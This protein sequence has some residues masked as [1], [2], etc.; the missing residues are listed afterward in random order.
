MNQLLIL[1]HIKRALMV[2]GALTLLL[3]AGC[4]LPADA[5]SSARSTPKVLKILQWEHFVPRYDEWFDSYA[6]Q[7]GETNGVTVVVDHVHV[8]ELG[9]T[10]TAE[11]AAGEGHDLI[12]HIIPPSRFEPDLSDLTDLNQEAQRRFG[13]QTSVC[14]RSSFNPHT[15]VFYGFCHGWVPDPG[16]YRK[17]LWELT[18]MDEGPYTWEELLDYGGRINQELSIQAGIGLSPEID[19]NMALR[20]LLWSYGA[21]VQDE[22]ENV[23]INSPETV[24]AI[25]YMGNLYRTAM[26]EEVFD[27]EPISNN[28][29]L[30]SA[31]ASYILN[32]ISAYRTAQK[33]IPDIADDL[34]FV[35]ALAGPN[36][37]AWASAHVINTY[38]VPKFSQNSDLAKKFILDLVESYDQA[39]FNSELYTF[40]AFYD[41]APELLAPGGWLDDDPFGSNPSNKLAFLKT[42]GQWSTNLG[43]PGPA[44]AAI[45]E[46]FASSIIPKMFARSVRGEMTP[47][48]AASWAEE[49]ITPIFDKWRD[50]GL[51]GGGSD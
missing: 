42:A 33:I 29:A 9:S 2:A 41:T 27:W 35:P 8:T 26:T 10:I 47:E 39:V 5:D 4:Q 48:E 23:A 49:E 19:S 16:D 25:E 34:F 18:G 13:E 12:E 17:S 11:L 37:E 6:Q 38:T 22:Q 14:T 7:W 3:L 44:N 28:K 31:R 43:H 32:S 20:A 50:A 40:P 45:G 46:V 1:H 15:E 24:A 30:V 36:G 51:V 21:S